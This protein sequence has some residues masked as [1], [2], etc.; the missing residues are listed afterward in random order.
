MIKRDVDGLLF[1]PTPPPQNQ[2]KQ[3][4]KIFLPDW[5]HKS[6]FPAI[7]FV[8]A[9]KR[10]LRSAHHLGNSL[11]IALDSG[12]SNSIGNRDTGVAGNVYLYWSPPPG[13]KSTTS[14]S[15]LLAAVSETTGCIVGIQA[16]TSVDNECLVVL[17]CEK[18]LYVMK[19][20][21]LD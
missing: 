19:G 15:A 3:Q 21:N 17:L 14:K 16:I 6:T 1:Y 4:S 9:S 13:S 5:I 2:Q 7:D 20:L 12:G 11:V 18:C 8:L 10:S